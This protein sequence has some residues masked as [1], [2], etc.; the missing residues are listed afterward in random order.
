MILAGLF[1]VVLMGFAA[2]TVD[3]GVVYVEK[4]DLQNA[5][6][7]AAL[8]AAADLPDSGTARTTAIYYAGQNGVSSDNVAVD[9]QYSG[10]SSMVEVVCTK[11]VSYSFA[12]VLGFT[13]TQVSARAV[14]QKSGGGGGGGGADSPFGYALFAGSENHQCTLNGAGAYVDG[15]IHSNYRVKLNGAGMYT[16]GSI[17]ASSKIQISGAGSTVLG[18]CQAP[19]IKI[20]GAGQ[21]IGGKDYSAAPIID[22]PDYSD[23]LLALAQAAGQYY[24]GNKK[25]SGSNLSIDDPIYV[26]GNLTISGA[27]FSGVGFIVATGNITFTG[28]G[29][30]YSGDDALCFYSVNGDIT[31]NGA[32]IT[33]DGLVYAPNGT[34]TLSGAG[35]VV[36]GRIIADNIVLHGA[37]HR[38]ISG[39]GDLDVLPG[40][41][42]IIKLVE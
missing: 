39:E 30:T 27:G 25:L 13:D 16:T 15:N 3:L 23:E 2:I 41:E 14:A 35:H 33:I 20:S 31:A 28:S 40:G 11:T 7:A 34:V 29:L 21:S 8:A 6:D 4:T 10:D 38:V 17:T 5:A 36:N 12:R 19:K 9:T 37:G 22:M 42:E 18:I 26:N 24:N 1:L 32:G